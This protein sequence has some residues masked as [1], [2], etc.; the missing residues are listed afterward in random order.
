MTISLG[1]AGITGRLG[2]LCADEARS[3]SDITLTG[4]L[5]RVADPGRAIVTDP[6]VLAAGCDVLL[7]V[8][9]ADA[10]EAVAEA[11]MKAGCAL[12]TG[13]TGLGPAQEAALRRA[14]GVIPVVRAANFSP[15]LNLMLLAAK[16]LAGR[17]PDFD[18]EIVETHHRQKRDAPSGTALAIG[19][20]VATGRGMRLADVM[21]VDRNRVRAEGE[22]GFAS[23]RAGQIVGEHQLSFTDAFEQITLGHRA[24]DRRLFARGALLAVRWAAGRSPGF[25]GMEDVVGG[26]FP[27]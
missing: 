5:A 16:M 12:V 20:A 10:V 26:G 21:Q 4:G 14:S 6:G 27:G 15:A 24:F 7:D 19:E 9:S 22:I 23:L 25:Y 13:T 11:A 8:S 18:A 17:L 1:I 2:A 3:A